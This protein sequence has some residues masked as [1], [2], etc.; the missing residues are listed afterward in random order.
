MMSRAASRPE[1]TAETGCD[2]AAV[3]PG[4][5]TSSGGSQSREAATESDAGTGATNPE[6]E[7]CS[8]HCRKGRRNVT[9]VDGVVGGLGPRWSKKGR[10]TVYVGVAR[11]P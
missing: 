2:N 4:T 3:S 11:M 9:S 8:S 5:K 6:Y 1:R 7:T 10:I